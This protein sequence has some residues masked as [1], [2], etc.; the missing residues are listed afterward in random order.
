MYKNDL[1]HTQQPL[2]GLCDGLTKHV[3]VHMCV[4][5]CV[6]FRICM[7]VSISEVIQEVQGWIQGLWGLKLIKLLGP[8]KK[9][10]TKLHKKVNIHLELENYKFK[11][12]DKYHNH[13]KSMEKINNIFNN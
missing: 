11:K 7:Y 10:K 4:C 9:N 12:A 3:Y 5:V 6:C 1:F 2:F 8:F 13:K